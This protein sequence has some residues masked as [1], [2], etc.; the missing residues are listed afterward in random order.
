MKRREVKDLVY[1]YSLIIIIS[2]FI[3]STIASNKEA[4][5]SNL[6]LIEAMK[7]VIVLDNRLNILEDN[8]EHLNSYIDELEATNKDILNKDALIKDL[9]RDRK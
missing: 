2:W 6:K 8:I 1:I 7:V 4:Y 5:K 9:R 3:V